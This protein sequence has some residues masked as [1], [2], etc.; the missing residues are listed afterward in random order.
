MAPGDGMIAMS[1]KSEVHDQAINDG[2]IWRAVIEP[3][4]TKDCRGSNK[5][6]APPLRIGEEENAPTV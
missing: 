1:P 2:N 4:T 3:R 6:V 5:P